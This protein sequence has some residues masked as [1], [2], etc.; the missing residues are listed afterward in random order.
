[1]VEKRSHC[2]IVYNAAVQQ[3]DNPAL[4]V[5]KRG[6]RAIARRIG[7]VDDQLKLKPVCTGRHIIH[8]ADKAVN[9]DVVR[10]DEEALMKN[11]EAM[12]R[13]AG[14][15]KRKQTYVMVYNFA[16]SMCLG[17]EPKYEGLLQR[18]WEGMKR[19]QNRH[20]KKKTEV[21]PKSQINTLGI[22][23]TGV[24][25]PQIVQNSHEATSTAMMPTQQ[26]VQAT[27]VFADAEDAQEAANPASNNEAAV[28]TVQGIPSPNHRHGTTGE[29][30][31]EV[32]TIVPVFNPPPTALRIV[33]LSG[34]LDPAPVLD[35]TTAEHLLN[36]ADKFP[37]HSQGKWPA[38]L[39]EFQRLKPHPAISQNALRKR[40]EK[41]NQKKNKPLTTTSI[42]QQRASSV[43]PHPTHTE[44]SNNADEL[45]TKC[46]ASACKSCRER[47]RKCGP[48]SINPH[49]EHRKRSRQ[50]TIASFFS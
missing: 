23:A 8:A 5:K 18:R 41:Y 33:P 34:S 37:R 45:E 29:S 42:V 46:P 19:S 40:L 30:V 20:M 9:D 44:T 3:L 35:E 7:G 4:G 47:K 48:S 27:T 22:D 14:L 39:G 12:V 16:A 24:T 1:V 38:L 11:L 28:L 13:T 43:N 31:Q 6:F 17:I 25:S 49:C 10:P 26:S 15:K 2:Y 32:S 21:C 50:D 36:V